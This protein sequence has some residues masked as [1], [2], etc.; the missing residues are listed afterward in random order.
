M[1]TPSS[2]RPAPT[3]TKARWRSWARGLPAVD[4]RPTEAVAAHVAAF[5]RDLG[6]PV[7][8]YLALDDEVSVQAALTDPTLGPFALPRLDDDGTMSVHLDDGGRECHPLGIEQPVATRPTV[9]PRRLAAVLV[10]ARVFDRDGFRLGRG[11]GHYDRLLPRLRRSTPVLGVSVEARLVDR[12]PRE[13]HDRAMTHL[14]TESG[15]RKIS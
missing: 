9:D 2:T 13:T 10:P 14:V 11:G 7:L 8:A 6:S 12:L 15:V 3:D 4:E 5:L 1:S